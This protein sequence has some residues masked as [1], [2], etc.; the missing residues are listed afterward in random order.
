MTDPSCKRIRSAV[1]VD[2]ASTTRK[3]RRF[4]KGLKD[5]VLNQLDE[6]LRREQIGNIPTELFHQLLKGGI[7]WC[8]NR[9]RSRAAVALVNQHLEAEIFLQVRRG[10]GLLKDGVVRTVSNPRPNMRR[11]QPRRR[12]HFV[13]DVRHTVE[14][15]KSRLHNAGSVH[16]SPLSIHR[17]RQLLSLHCGQG[18]TVF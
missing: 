17:H 5:V 15:L 16:K 6:V 4:D 2:E 14:R 1:E 12:E 7:R 8:P 10:H 11:R 3:I 13:D 9:P 18:R